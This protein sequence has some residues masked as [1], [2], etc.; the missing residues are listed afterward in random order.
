MT[1]LDKLIERSKRNGMA[2]TML[3]ANNK[4]RAKGIDTIFTLDE[5]SNVIESCE[6]LVIDSDDYASVSDETMKSMLGE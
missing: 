2:S 4:C 5:I 1:N 6:N 3:L